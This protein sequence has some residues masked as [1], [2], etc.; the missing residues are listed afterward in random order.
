LFFPG[1]GERLVM[2]ENDVAS[3]VLWCLGQREDLEGCG[4]EAEWLSGHTVFPNAG[5]L[6]GS[7]TST[8]V[9]INVNTRS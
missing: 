5:E 3:N 4:S 6:Y 9:F 1:H 8:I 7:F 2:D